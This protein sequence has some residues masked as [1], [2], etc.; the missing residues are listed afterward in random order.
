VLYNNTGWSWFRDVVD[1]G[2]M[3]VYNNILYTTTP[4]YYMRASTSS[5]GSSDTWEFKNNVIYKTGGGGVEFATG[6]NFTYSTNLYYGAT[7]PAK[8]AQA[9]SA[10]P[11]FVGVPAFST[12]TSVA[13][14]FSDFSLL[15]P[16]VGSPMI[17]RGVA[18]TKSSKIDILVNNK[19]YAGVT[20]S[21]A[22]DLGLFAV[23]FS[24]LAGIVTDP[25]MGNPVSGAEVK[26]NNTLKATTD[27]NGKYSLPSVPYGAYTIEVTHSG[28][29][30]STTPFTANADALSYLALSS[31]EP[32]GDTAKDV[33]GTITG[34]GG[35]LSGVTVTITKEG[36]TPITATSG[37]DGKYTLVGVPAGSGYTITAAKSG[38][39]SKETSDFLVPLTGEP[40][41]ANFILLATDDIYLNED[42]NTLDNWN[43]VD[44]TAQV[45]I[46]TVADPDDAKNK[47]FHI[48]KLSGTG[49]GGI[50]NKT[51]VGATG[52]FTIETRMKRNYVPPTDGQYQLYTY[53]GDKFSGNANASSANS[54]ANIIMAQDIG[55]HFTTG[56]SATTTMQTHQINTWYE[57][58][59]RVDTANDTFDFYVDG[60]KK[61]SGNLRTAVDTIDIFN[62][63]VG[64]DGGWGDFWLDYIRVY[65]G[66][67]L[68]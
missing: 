24:G 26:L 9:I 8:D 62:I 17:N 47:L 5:G 28:F 1:N 68:F 22:P 25:V 30:G 56:S 65:K 49:T 37:A 13:S 55:T 27:T 33:K 19:D 51:S 29:M 36:K 40:A 60:V 16:A 46:D 23:D 64:A 3:Q 42:F 2:Y 6:G 59:L 14:R 34:K 67:P 32:A 54:S 4:G 21:G 31:G 10:D 58:K 15:R 12:G 41:A 20:L 35:A 57:I 50:Y 48:Y 53:Q 18:F 61:G 45:T 52:V 66:E 43:I 7:P 38:Y 11:L 63:W 44:A 39:L